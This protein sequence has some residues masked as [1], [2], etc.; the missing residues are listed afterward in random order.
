VQHFQFA[1]FSLYNSLCSLHLPHSRIHFTLFTSLFPL[2]RALFPPLFAH[3]TSRAPLALS[4]L[5]LFTRFTH[6]LHSLHSRIYLHSHLVTHRQSLS[7]TILF[8]H[9]LIH[10][11][12]QP[13]SA[14]SL[15]HSALSAHS[16]HVTYRSSRNLS[17]MDKVHDECVRLQVLW[18]RTSRPVDPRR[19]RRHF[20]SAFEENPF[21]HVVLGEH[22]HTHTHTHTNTNTNTITH[23]HTPTHAR[24]HT[25]AHAHTHH[26]TR[27]CGHRKDGSGGI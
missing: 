2:T 10:L 3:L 13:L 20:H 25:H 9:L 26:L 18:A 23:T 6:S 11:I 8:A 5:T 17:L 1:F 24:T 4:S 14:H 7:S 16:P 15:H 12:T 22:T 27:R 21:A 19:L